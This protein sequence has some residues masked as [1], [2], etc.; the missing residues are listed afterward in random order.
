LYRSVLKY[1]WDKFKLGILEYID[2]PNNFSTEEKKELILKREQ[3]FL[4]LINPDLNICKTATSPLGVK[5]TEDFSLRLSQSRRG[6]SIKRN[7]FQINSKELISKD[8]RLK[9]S[10]RC[11]GISVKIYD[12]K[13]NNLIREFPTITSAAKYLGVHRKTITRIY[14]TGESFDN[15]IYQFTIKDTRI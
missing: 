8:T 2:I 11:Q 14:T 10:T 3:Y 5:R 7:T 1:G 4:N 6:K 15:F 13:D 12:K 9:I